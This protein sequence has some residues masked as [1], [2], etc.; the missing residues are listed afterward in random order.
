MIGIGTCAPLLIRTSTN[1]ATISKK[2]NAQ[3]NSNR[4]AV[5]LGL[6]WHMNMVMPMKVHPAPIFLRKATAARIA[7]SLSMMFGN[8]A[9]VKNSG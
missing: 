8:I 1:A 7:S 2:P 9:M 3:E 5:D 6:F 4:C